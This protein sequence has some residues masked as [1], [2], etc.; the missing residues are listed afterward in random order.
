MKRRQNFFPSSF[1]LCVFTKK[2]ICSQKDDKTFFFFQPF[3]SVQDIRLTIRFA[4][5]Y[6]KTFLLCFPPFGVARINKCDTQGKVTQR[7]KGKEITTHRYKLGLPLWPRSS[8]REILTVIV[9][10]RRHLLKCSNDEKSELRMAAIFAP[11]L[12]ASV[13]S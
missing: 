9:K 12:S 1:T 4:R 6:N 8:K 5:G 3:R 7:N 2:T 13:S 11:A 10:R